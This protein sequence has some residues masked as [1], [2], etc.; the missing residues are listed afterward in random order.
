MNK[1]N[2]E[3]GRLDINTHGGLS[4]VGSLLSN[5]TLSASFQNGRS[6][7]LSDSDYIFSMLGLLSVGKSSFAD[8]SSYKN[9]RMFTHCLDLD[10]LPSEESLRQN[11]NRLALNSKTFT[12]V[13]N[14]NTSLLATM[15]YSAIPCETGDYYP[16]DLDVT[17]LENSKSKKEGVSCTY[18]MFDGFAP[19]MAY[20]GRIGY[21]VGSEF[22]E[23]KQYCQNGTAAFLESAIT[24]SNS[25]LPEESK[26][27]IRMDGGN[28]AGENL[29]VMFYSGSYW[30]V[31]R[32]LRKEPKTYW[33]E[34]A[35]IMGELVSDDGVKRVYRGVI[36]HIDVKYEDEGVTSDI[37]FEV[38]E[39]YATEE[40]QMKMLIE[41]AV[42]TYWTN[43]PETP[44]VVIDLYHDHGT[45]EQFHSEFKTDMGVE[46]L[47]SGNFNTN[48]L[49]FQLAMV[50]YN[51]LRRIS[52]DIVEFAPERVKSKGVKRRRLKTV[53][54]S[55]INSGCQ[56]IKKAGTVTIRFGRNCASYRAILL[57]YSI[58]Q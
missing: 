54:Q 15:N 11:L 16:L 36:S 20:L 24:T 12:A 39:T 8:I 49:I 1:I 22:R 43:L 17:P 13:S 50:A 2:I 44:E 45:S 18:K 9:N 41:I 58:Y 21:L 34:I 29:E 26:I 3:Q 53:L 27:L 7:K 33:L 57:L 30:I 52:I 48:K 14:L 23:G 55:I 35:Q 31:K 40:G 32:N 38:T 47:P 10:K 46:R 19:M 51:L 37:V 6:N 4:L 42:D 56:F 25:L 28:D 5:I